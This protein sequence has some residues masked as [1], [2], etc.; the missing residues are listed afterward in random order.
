MEVKGFTQG[1][2]G[3]DGNVGVQSKCIDAEVQGMFL[4]KSRG[5]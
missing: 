2:H 4:E 3:G 5:K 1:H